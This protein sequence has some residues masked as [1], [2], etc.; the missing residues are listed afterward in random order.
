M[1][2]DPCR[3]I[4]Y[5]AGPEVVHLIVVGKAAFHDVEAVAWAG[6][7]GRQTL[8]R[9]TG[10]HTFDCGQATLRRLH[11]GGQTT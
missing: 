5:E 9:R 11:L 1:N 8:A 2:N 3:N 10:P 6:G 4:T 7:D